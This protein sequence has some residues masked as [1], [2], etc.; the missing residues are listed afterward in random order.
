MFEALVVMLRE[1]VEAA[2]VVGIILAYLRKIGRDDLNRSAY[3]GLGLAVGAS[4]LGALAL[5]RLHFSEELF[6]GMAML[7]GAVFVGTMIIWMWRTARRLKGQIEQRVDRIVGQAQSGYSLGLVTFTFLMVFREGVEAV[8]FLSAVN[9]TTDA[10]LSFFGG[11]MGLGL[12]VALGVAFF[13]GAVR[14]DLGRFFK[15]TGIV[16]LVFACQL[17]IG[18]VHEL[19]EAGFIALGPRE[20]G[21]VGP[22]V[23]NDVP[24]ILAIIALPLILTFVPGQQERKRWV[25][26]AALQ[27]AEKR[28]QLAQ[29]KR[30]KRWRQVTAA[31]GVV[32][33]TA[34]TVNYAYSRH[35][36]TIDPPEMVQADHGLVKVALA[37]INDGN[38]HRFGY[39]AGDAVIRFLALKTEGGK[40]G[41]AF[42]ACRICGDYGYVQ[43]GRNI[44][45][46]NCAADIHAPTIGQGGGCNPIP[47]ASRVEGDHLVIT[48]NELVQGGTAFAGGSTME[49][50]DPVCGMKLHLSDA[51]Q[52]M[53]YQGTTYYFCKMP[54][55]A[56]AFKEHP[57]KYAH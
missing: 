18:G 41:T 9:L 16:L 45:C 31:V 48:V 43:E 27:G 32:I 50:T 51:G 34:L 20:M 28:K 11:L 47:L 25:E 13:K 23:K 53:A 14:I 21:L 40:I 2:L 36:R 19:A 52:Q 22:I 46:L 29:L 4:L 3:L 39:Q 37:E 15:V 38:L 17:L 42:D 44:V 30:A 56:A 57:E 26:A 54:T 10:L 8:L 24:F 7:L 5:S 12:A 6:E 33:M 35:P 1:G 49:V 55:C